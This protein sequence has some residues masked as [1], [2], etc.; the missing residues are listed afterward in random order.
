[1]VLS[2]CDGSEH[3]SIILP[4]GAGDLCYIIYAITTMATARGPM[5][6]Y[7]CD[8]NDGN[9][10]TRTANQNSDSDGDAQ[11]GSEGHRCRRQTAQRCSVGDNSGNDD[12]ARR[13]APASAAP[14][15]RTISY[16]YTSEL[17]SRVKQGEGNRKGEGQ[18]QR[19]LRPQLLR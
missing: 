11:E 16:A 12:A 19:Q 13:R 7:I 5:L 18:P 15:R 2:N 4:S 10:K 14:P 6:Y 8:N 17:V 1:M 3:K 9:S